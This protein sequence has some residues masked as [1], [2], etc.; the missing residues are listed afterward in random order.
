[1]SSAFTRESDSGIAEDVGERPVSTH[2]NLVTPRGFEA[3]EQE[4]E[5][6]RVA[7]ATAEREQDRRA[8]ALAARD[9]NYW[10]ARRSN[11]ELVK[12]NPDKAEVRFG[13]TVTLK[14]SGG[15]TIRY[16]IVGEDEADPAKGSIPH[17]APLARALLGKSVG[18]EVDVKRAPAEIVAI[19]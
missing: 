9:L 18:D 2:R 14:T 6:S 19:D 11:A 4:L 10:S 3:I 12:P 7:L 8:I 5:A 16:A 1:M 15:E 17:V 13:H